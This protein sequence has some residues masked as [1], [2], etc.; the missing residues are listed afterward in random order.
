M[1]RR[2]WQAEA[3][4]VNGATF[5]FGVHGSLPGA[6]LKSYRLLATFPVEVD[7]LRVE[8]IYWK[9][10]RLRERGERLQAQVRARPTSESEPSAGISPS[11][12]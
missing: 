8:R 6:I 1:R 5:T 2:A 10:Y 12:P 3:T 4:F 9:G 11:H 7:H